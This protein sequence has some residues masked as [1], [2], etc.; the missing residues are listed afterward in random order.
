MPALPP[1]ATNNSFTHALNRLPA[2]SLEELSKASLMDRTDTKF[3]FPV[4]VLPELLEQVR[5]YYGVLEMNGSRCIPYESLYFDTADFDLYL[6]HHNGKGKRHKIR[7]RRYVNSNKT[8]FEIKLKNPQGRTIKSRTSV[9]GICVPL[10]EKAAQLLEQHTLLKPQNIEPVLWVWYY[11]ITLLSLH[12][13]ERIT[14]D[15]GLHYVT[16]HKQ[17]AWQNMCILEVKQNSANRHS[18]IIDALKQLHIHPKSLS[19]YCTGVAIT[20]P[21]LK[22]NQFKSKLLQ[23]E[24]IEHL[25][26]PTA[27]AGASGN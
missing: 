23:I 18:V 8:Y 16:P 14:I 7:Y 13:P 20:Y 10:G 25:Y 19:K 11:R 6:Q 22:Y 24:K 4:Q 3:F 17:A 2:V 21:Q 1:V 15:L 9:P 26:A 5:N 27:I 12:F